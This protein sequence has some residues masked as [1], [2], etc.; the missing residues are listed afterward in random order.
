[1]D[2]RQMHDKT[3]GGHPHQ[4]FPLDHVR[5]YGYEVVGW[6]EHEVLVAKGHYRCPHCRR[7]DTA[8]MSATGISR[9]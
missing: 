6:R 1:M 4:L 5:P 9:R 2:E 7:A 3:L 8:E